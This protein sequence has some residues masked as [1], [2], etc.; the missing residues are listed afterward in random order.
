ME[1][2]VLYEELA[3]GDH[4]IIYK[5]RRKGTINF[6][7]IHCIDKCKRPEVTNTVRMTHDIEHENIVRFHE[8]YETSNHLWL[9]VELCTGGSLE[10]LIAQDGSLPESTVRSFGIQLVTGLH[11]IHSLNILFHDLRPS[12]ILLD[13][14]GSLKY[15]DFSSSKVEGENL[16]ELFYKFAESGE[17]WNTQSVEEMMKFNKW[18]GS[19]IYMAPELIQGAEPNVLSDLWSLGCVLY[20]MFAGY[21]PFFAES[22]EQIKDRVLNKDFP[23]PKVKGPRISAKPS[24]EFLNLLQGL[25][26][27]DPTQRL[28][29]LKLV[30]H[31]FWQGQ[32]SSL[33]KDLNASADV[34][35]STVTNVVASN[36]F[37]HGVSS[38]LG[39]VK[40]VDIKKSFDRPAINLDLIDGSRP[41]TVVGIS[42][43]LRPKTAPGMESGG[44]LFTLSARPHTA[45]PPDDRVTSPHRPI[46]TPLKTRETIGN[47]TDGEASIQDNGSETKKLIFHDS[48]FIITQIVDNPKIQKVPQCKYDLKI[49]PVPPFTAEKLSS[50]SDKEVQKQAKAI[51]DNLTQAEK[52]PPSQ[53]R[54]HLLQYL[55]CVASCHE[56]STSL[57][58]QGLL[59]TIAKQIKESSHVDIKL[60]L[61]RALALVAHFTDTV[62]TSVNLSEAMSTLTEL[63]RENMKNVKLK[64]G[65]LPALG[66]LIALVAAQEQRGQETVENWTVPTLAYTSI[67]RGIRE[68]SSS[69][70]DDQVVNH[71]CIKIIE[72]VTASLSTHSQKFV[73]QEVCQSLWYM[74]K[75]TSV[76]AIRITTISALCRLTWQNPAM[77]QSI[78]DSGA[79]T[80]IMQ[81]L[82]CG[83]SRIQQAIITMI[84]FYLATIGNSSRFFQDK[85]FC[86]KVMRCFESPSSIIRAKAFVVVYE[87]VHTNSELLLSCCQARLVMYIER[88]SRRQ[89]PRTPKIKPVED[90]EYLTQCLELLVSGI[91]QYL[92]FIMN[93][94]LEHLDQVGG[95]KHPNTA[96][97]KQLK[98]SLPLMPVFNHMVTSQVFR[99]AVVNQQFLHQYIKLLNHVVKIEQGETNIDSASEKGK[100][101]ISV[102]EFVSSTLSI[103]EGI[104]QHPSLL[105]EHNALIIKEIIPLLTSLIACQNVDT[106][107]QALQVFGD[108]ASVYLSQD[109]FGSDVKVNIALLRNIIQEKL[110]PQ[111]E[112]I[113]L[114]LDPLPSYALKLM[115]AFLEHDPS[116]IK[117]MEQ[118]GLIAVL[119]QTLMDHQNNALSRVMQGVV[120]VLNCLVSHKETNMLELYDQGLVDHITNLLFDVWNSVCDGEDG[121]RD[122]KTAVTMLLTLLDTLHSILRYVSEVVRKALQVKNKGGEGAQKEAEFGEQLLLLNKSLTDLTSLLTQLLCYEDIEIQD[123]AIKCLSLLVQLFGGENREAMAPDNMEC[124][125]KCLKSFDPKKQKIVLRVIK[126]LLSTNSRHVESMKKSGEGLAKTIQSLANTASSHADITLSTVAAEILKMTGHMS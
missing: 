110:L 15:A 12:K 42:E 4:S 62:D 40:S 17:Q 87:L 1:N 80:P 73:T 10:S 105:I 57:T 65:L 89:T 24:P 81:A 18:T 7:A 31:S 124:Y 120:A 79:L 69:D 112:P 76:D 64:Q 2:F 32:L 28:D 75:H 70:E 71:I 95:R 93:E 33:A 115:L 22:D 106:K 113:L 63:L 98:C 50:M 67:I 119:F 96:Q 90:Q 78:L 47:T 103:L 52:G 43:Y 45:V 46:Q 27:K 44:G 88:D 23:I 3:K 86:V 49:L 13:T 53:K 36:V 85:D 83:V 55:A 97:I 104:S 39:C 19:L 20:Q 5:G 100:A 121:G 94:I 77:F 82:N 116:F 11:Y 74:F 117:L 102:P 37:D 21:P 38:A 109:Q 59:G 66:E 41:S 125:S 6:V 30:N 101:A 26:K 123:L 8:W 51:A 54:I 48:D 61:A 111:F 72:T 16:E 114:D 34:R 84:G 108:M 92:P 118:Q 68:G 25:L 14:A 29:W 126:R 9:V 60:K 58:Q 107:A 35:S 56:L 91:L 122:I 99:T